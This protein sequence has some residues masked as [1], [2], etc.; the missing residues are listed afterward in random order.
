[1]TASP[2]FENEKFDEAE[3]FLRKV[4]EHVTADEYNQFIAYIKAYAQVVDYTDR[5]AAWKHIARLTYDLMCLCSEYPTLLYGYTNFLPVDH[6]EHA[7]YCIENMLN[8]IDMMEEEDQALTDDVT[9]DDFIMDEDEAELW[10]V[11]A[12]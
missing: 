4:K 12:G 9:E 10:Q 6:R 3:A 7:R 1:M 2:R 5:P 8:P 11:L